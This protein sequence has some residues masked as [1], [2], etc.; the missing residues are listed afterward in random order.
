ME[1]AVIEASKAIGMEKQ[2]AKYL[3]EILPSLFFH[4]LLYCL[5]L[6]GAP[7]LLLSSALLLLFDTTLSCFVL[8]AHFTICCLTT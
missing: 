1:V 6:S 2:M 3:A 8:L 4:L 7:L 5:L